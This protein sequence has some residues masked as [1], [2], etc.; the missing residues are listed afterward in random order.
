[1][2]FD[3]EILAQCSKLKYLA[4]PAVGAGSY[5]DMDATIDME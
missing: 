2:K 4:I 5:V 3:E 1:M